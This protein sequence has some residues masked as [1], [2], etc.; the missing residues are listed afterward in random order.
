[1]FRKLNRSFYGLFHE[2]KNFYNKI[3]KYLTT[4]G[5]NIYIGE[6]CLLNKQDTY[7]GLYV[8]D[9]L[10]IGTSDQVNH[11]INK[12]KIRFEVLIEKNLK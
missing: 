8:D 12:I 6:P 11:I 7:I 4:K 9:L 5:F 3:T 2:E 1:M 10:I